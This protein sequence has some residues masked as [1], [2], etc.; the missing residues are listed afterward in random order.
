MKFGCCTGVENISILEEAGYDYVEL[1][2][3][4]LNPE[5]SEREFQ[6]LKEKIL[7]HEIKPEVFNRFLPLDLKIVG[8]D[9][10]PSRIAHYVDIAL[11]RTKELGGKIVVFGSGDS[12]KIPDDFPIGRVNLKNA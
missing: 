3:V 11:R 7:S 10:N 12:R 6:K 8:Q 4:S 9:A 1:P 5:G 2:V